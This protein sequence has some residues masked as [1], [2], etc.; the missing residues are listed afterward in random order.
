MHKK[1]VVCTQMGQNWPMAGCISTRHYIVCLPSAVQLPSKT[2]QLGKWDFGQH[3]SMQYCLAICQYFLARL[4]PLPCKTS[5]VHSF[6][7]VYREGH[8]IGQLYC[9]QICFRCVKPSALVKRWTSWVKPFLLF[10]DWC[11]IIYQ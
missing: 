2:V 8:W 5:M 6:C 7:S 4:H 3:C 10:H 9:I 11:V 1:L